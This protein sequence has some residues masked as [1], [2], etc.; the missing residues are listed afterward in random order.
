MDI[1]DKFRNK[2]HFRNVLIIII[3]LLIA[4]LGYF[5]RT[6]QFYQFPPSGDTQ[7]ELKA[8]FNGVNLIKY[9][10]PRSWSWFEEYGD[11]PTEQIRNGQFRIVEP[12]FD[13]PPLFSLIT[14]VYALS[15]GMDSLDKIDAG[16]MRWPMIKLAALN[17]FLLFLLIWLIRNPLEAIAGSLIYAT[18]PTFVV[19]SRMPLSEN[20]IVTC[21]LASLICFVLYIRKNKIWFLILAGII[22]SSAFLMKNTAI[23]IP[24][25]LILL[26]IAYKQY[27]AASVVFG[28]ALLSLIIWL[29]F[30]YFYNWPLFINLLVTYSGRELFQPT[31]IINLFEVF[32]IGEKVMDPDGWIIWGWIS[33]IVY[34]LIDKQEEGEK[35]SK[36]LLPLTIGS[37]LVYFMIMS[38][39]LKGWYRIPFYPFLSWASAAFIIAIFKNPNILLSLFFL[40]IPVASSYIY[41]NGEIKWNDM[42]KKIFQ[43]A[44]PLMVLPSFLYQIADTKRFKTAAQT[45]IVIA[46]IAA[47]IF[48]IRTILYFQSNFWY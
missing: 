31:N 23:F 35:I 27:K 41:G 25:S 15:K 5:L 24:T 8:V 34:T 33:V 16:A 45:I 44:F 42:G 13:E 38:G 9:G 6:Q 43:Y 26:S 18:V 12:W 48:N 10:V 21:A 19:G 39:H 2:D 37:Y 46:F 7:D 29:G 28:F 14:G 20:M 4:Y 1:L 17:I 40:G 3:G 22:G 36:L 11:F 47:I 30:G 32:R